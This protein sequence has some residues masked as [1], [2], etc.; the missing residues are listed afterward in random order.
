MK[1]ERT[2]FIVSLIIGNKKKVVEGRGKKCRTARNV[3]SV[4][5]ATAGVKVRECVRKKKAV[6]K[7]RRRGKRKNVNGKG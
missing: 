5:Y 4:Q 6:G 3:L 7:W 1:C 2:K